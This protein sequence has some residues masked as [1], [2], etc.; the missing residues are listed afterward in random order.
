M[1]KYRVKVVIQNDKYLFVNARNEEQ[2]KS[3]AQ[4]IVE[5]WRSKPEVVE[6]EIDEELSP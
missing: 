2:A 6:V 1:P 5:S 3:D 4:Y